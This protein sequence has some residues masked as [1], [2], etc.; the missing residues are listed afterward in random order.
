M[1]IAGVLIIGCMLL[2]MTILGV[3]VLKDT[4][5]EYNQYD[6]KNTILERILAVLYCLLL[7]FLW[8]VFLTN[9]IIPIILWK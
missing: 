6:E 4:F 9:A 2:C 8:S 5:E 7:T 3:L 1:G